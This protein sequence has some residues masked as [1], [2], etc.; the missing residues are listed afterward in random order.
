MP[1]LPNITPGYNFETVLTALS[2][3]SVDLGDCNADLVSTTTLTVDG[4]PWT[5]SDITDVAD[6]KTK[7]QNITATSGVTNVTGTL[8]VSG[9]TNCT[10]L[11]LSG[12][13]TQSSGTSQFKQTTVDSLITSGNIT[14]NTPGV[15]NLQTVNCTGLNCSGSASIS[16]WL[17]PPSSKSNGSGAYWNNLY[18]YDLKNFITMTSPPNVLKVT[19]SLNWGGYGVY[20]YLEFLS[21]GSF[22]NPACTGATTY[23]TTSYPWATGYIPLWYNNAATTTGTLVG[24]IQFTHIYTSAGSAKVYAVT[25]TAFNGTSGPTFSYGGTVNMP[26]ATNVDGFRFTTSTGSTNYTTSYANC[27]YY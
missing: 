10:T 19:F 4:E 13:A 25:G 8:N 11:A 15:S 5:A 1:N 27:I 20:P 12:N 6:I 18:S 17:T 21:G 22:T 2:L 7:V 9:S 3:K 26:Y 23:S 16:S 24:Q 14:Q